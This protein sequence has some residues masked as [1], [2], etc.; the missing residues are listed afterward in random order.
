MRDAKAPNRQ[1]G[2]G[3]AEDGREV[4]EA[5]TREWRGGACHRPWVIPARTCRTPVCR[6]AILAVERRV[7][8]AEPVLGDAAL[9]QPLHGVLLGCAVGGPPVA[10]HDV[11][12]ITVAGLVPVA[13]DEQ[14]GR[15]MHQR[16]AKAPNL[17]VRQRTDEGRRSWIQRHRCRPVLGPL[18][19]DAGSNAHAIELIGVAQHGAPVVASLGDRRR[20]D[21]PV[22]ARAVVAHELDTALGGGGIADVGPSHVVELAVGATQEEAAVEQDEA[23]ARRKADAA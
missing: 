18:V 10:V 13:L 4:G 3:H 2:I 21:E 9:D 16:E 7:A 11:A 20:V 15:D 23:R 22:P 19:A 14:P 17:D 5:I 6:L 1:L 12:R 8:I